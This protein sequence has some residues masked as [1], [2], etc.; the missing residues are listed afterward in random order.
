MRGF[1]HVEGWCSEAL[2]PIVDFIDSL[3]MS[4]EGGVCE[5]GVHHG[6]FFLLLNQV[7]GAHDRSF[8]VDVFEDQGL[9]VDGSG[10]GS[11]EAFRR[12]LKLYDAHQGR[13]TT[14]IRAD[15]TD[16]E[17]MGE[18]LEKSGRGSIRFFSIDGGHTVRHTMSD[19]R[20]ANM[21]IRTSGIVFLDD[22]LNYHWLGVF[23]GTVKFLLEEP[24]LIPFAIGHNKLF[25][26]KR[27]YYERYFQAFENFALKTKV[28][29]FMGSRLVAL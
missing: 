22:I 3:G 23:E 26:C 6:K 29:P 28:V 13:N 21:L 12:N 24:T 16:L 4:E 5:I 18:L 11:A 17:A 2:F 1:P 20:L 14:L 7:T 27:S 8:G 25:L 10:L 15:S 19:L 9:N